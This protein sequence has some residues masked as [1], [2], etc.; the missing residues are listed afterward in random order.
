M[1]ALILISALS[2]FSTDLLAAPADAKLKE[3]VNR[4]M[5]QCPGMEVLVTPL[6]GPAPANFTAYS[7]VQ[8]SSAKTCGGKDVALY[9]PASGQ[10][11]IG[12][13]FGLPADARTLEARVADV[14][15][16]LLRKDVVVTIDPAKLPDGIRQVT[17]AV[18]SAEGKMPLTGFI[19]SSG[20]YLVL[21]RRGS[22]SADPGKALS[23]T[24]AKDSVVTRGKAGAPITIV[25][26]SDLQC[27]ACRIAHEKLEPLIA[28]NL[29]RIQYRRVDLPIFEHHDWAMDAALGARAIAKVA[30]AKY[31]DYV[32]YIFE[33]QQ[34]IS[35]DQIDSIV[36]D[37]ADMHE[38]D[39]S[40]IEPLYQS[41]AERRAVVSQVGRLYTLGLF[42]TPTFIINGKEVFYGMQA[43][44]VEQHVKE[45][46]R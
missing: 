24:V 35:A 21:G 10:V 5:M 36:R 23:D 44:Y 20:G 27:P 34:E 45:L 19:D 6:E 30:P 17:M 29:H 12:N 11:L 15:E 28:A 39:W 13:V 1:K 32:E 40:K 43:D 38:L 18:E 16:R 33:H 2:L 46:L 3:Y 14:A 41:P 9:S 22:L 42:S 8:T 37:F 26:V 7:V 25:E 4:S 31:W